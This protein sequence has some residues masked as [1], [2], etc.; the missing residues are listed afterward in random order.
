MKKK[1]QGG[2]NDQLPQMQLRGS[3]KMKT[4]EAFGFSNREVVCDP[5]TSSFSGKLRESLSRVCLCENGRK[6]FGNSENRCA[7]EGYLPERG[8]EKWYGSWGALS[9][10]SY[11][12]SVY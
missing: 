2:R 4:R 8:R 3:S 11:S 10:R 7:F 1:F 6:G 12:M 5:D 9:G